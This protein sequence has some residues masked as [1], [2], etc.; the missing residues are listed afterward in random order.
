MKI[1][2]KTTIELTDVNTGEIEVVEEENMITN[3]L[4]YFFNSNPMGVFNHFN[5]TSSIKGYDNFLLPICPNLIG[6]LLL[7]NEPL[8]ED[9]EN[10]LPNCSQMPMGY[11][12]NNTNPYADIKRGSMNLTETMQ[13]TNGYKYVWDFA[14][15]Q[16]NGTIAALAL[17]NAYGGAAVYGSAYE[18]A[19]PFMLIKRDSITG[20]SSSMRVHFMESVELDVENEIVYSIQ[21]ATTGVTIYKIHLPIHQI[22]LLENLD[23]VNCEI[24]E[25]HTIVPSTFQFVENIYP[26]GTFLDG[27]DGYWYGFGNKGNSSGTATVYWI[28][29][30]KQDYSFTE[31]KWTLSGVYL[32]AFGIVRESSP[33]LEANAT[34]RNGYVYVMSNNRK[35]VYKVN[36]ENSADVTRLSL[37]ITSND[38]GLGE[39]SNDARNMILL[40]DVIIGRDFLIMADDTIVLTKGDEKIEKISSPAFQWKQYFIVWTASSRSIYL[41]TPFFVTINNLET[42]VVKTADK[43]MKITYTLTQET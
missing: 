32:K 4:H 7:F 6:G 5:N 41:L 9:P 18:D 37:G 23:G 2:G 33:Y 34:I 26:Q 15:S 35:N 16:A 17:T 25:E 24:I 11:A 29:I 31:G 10:L 20:L 13:I 14:T 22:G 27:K 3:A 39:I 8:K 36:L 43:T 38:Y 40:E 42:A 28:K 19:T 30:N 1:K 21:Y 12:S